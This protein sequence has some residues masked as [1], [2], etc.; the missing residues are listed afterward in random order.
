MWHLSHISIAE[1]ADREGATL[2]KANLNQDKLKIPD[3]LGSFLGVVWEQIM[4]G[5]LMKSV[6][7]R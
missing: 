3:G 7:S 2:L 6:S 4:A 1:D 5:I